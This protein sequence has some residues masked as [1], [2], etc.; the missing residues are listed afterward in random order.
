MKGEVCLDSQFQGT[1]VH[2]EGKHVSKQQAQQL[3]LS[4]ESSCLGHKVLRG[5]QTQNSSGP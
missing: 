1:T 4:A 2:P 5:E 3:E